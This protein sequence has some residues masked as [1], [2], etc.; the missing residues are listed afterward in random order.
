[1]DSEEVRKNDLIFMGETYFLYRNLLPFDRG[2]RFW[3]ID[4]DT[5]HKVA[6]RL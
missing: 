3:P 4:N 6:Q 2:V 5:L 1:M